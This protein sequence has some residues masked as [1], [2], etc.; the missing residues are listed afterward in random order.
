LTLH[1]PTNLDAAYWLLDSRL[2]QAV[3]MGARLLLLITG[4][5]PGSR[6]PP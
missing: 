6:E 3:G 4:K 2:E 1:G 5:P